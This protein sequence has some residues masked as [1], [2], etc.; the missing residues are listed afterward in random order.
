MHTRPRYGSNLVV[1]SHSRGSRR[2]AAAYQPKAAALAPAQQ[3]LKA[4]PGRRRPASTFHTQ[5]AWLVDPSG[6]VRFG[7]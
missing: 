3:Q 2:G 5:S 1:S 6:G 4:L 7:P